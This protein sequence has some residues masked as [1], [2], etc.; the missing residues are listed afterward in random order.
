VT[1]ALVRLMRR[2]DDPTEL[3]EDELL[4]AVVNARELRTIAEEV[5]AKELRGRG[6]ST[7][8]IAAGVGL[9]HKAIQAWI[10]RADARTAD[11]QKDHPVEGD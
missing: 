3:T 1:N 10:D 2:L 5:V 7:H 6:W 4:R 9:T 11:G 8:R